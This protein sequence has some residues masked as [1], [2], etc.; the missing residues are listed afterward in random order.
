MT[1]VSG[2]DVGGHRAD[3][4]P[5]STDALSDPPS[6]WNGLRDDCPAAWVERMGGFWLVSRYDDVVDIARA[7]D[8]FNNSGG[9][10]FGTSRPPLEVDRP[11]HAF[12]RR[13]LQPYFARERVETLEPQVRAYVAEMLAPLIDAGEGDLAEALTYPL[14]ARTLCLWLGLPDDEWAHIKGVSEELFRAEEGRG[15]D[16]ATRERCNQELYDFSRRLVRERIERP[17]DP[18]V[19]IISG[20]YGLTDGTST[21]TEETCVEI[22]RLLITAGHNSTTGG[23]G[24]SILRVAGEPEIQRRLRAEPDLIPSAVEEFLRLETPVQ[25]MPRWPNEDT[26]LHGRDV[27]A[28]EQVMLFWAAANRDPEQFPDP[29]RC[30]L[31]RS[32][33]QHVT[34]GRGIHR[35]IGLDLARLEIRVTL[36]ELL[37]R[38]AWFELAGEPTRTTFIRQGVSFLPLRLQRQEGSP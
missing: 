25:A 5:F 29:D 20:I 6:S 1:G 27:R 16:P 33:N 24:N 13:V 7:S 38:T 35:C 31:D 34:F 21:V 10:Q 18:S 23:L 2:T 36:Q 37:G 26:E 17:R 8:R 19:D 28:G 11:E 15:N 32:P 12:F 3:W 14:P 4:D 22:V 30:V 9:P